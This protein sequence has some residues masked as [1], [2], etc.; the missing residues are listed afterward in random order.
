MAIC[1]RCKQE[2]DGTFGSGRFCSRACANTRNHSEETKEKVSDSLKRKKLS[3]WNKGLTS[4][5]YRIAKGIERRNISFNKKL[6][7]LSFKLWQEL[8]IKQKR[9]IL[10]ES[11]DGK[12]LYCGHYQWL[13]KPL[14]L[15]LHHIDGNNTNQNVNNLEMLCPNCHSLTETFR[16]AN[17]NSNIGLIT[18]EQLIYALKTSKN[19]R[20]ALL[21]VGLAAKGNNYKRAKRLFE[22][23]SLKH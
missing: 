13:N 15:E 16:G 7:C 4:T 10:I 9:W 22:F 6:E 20:Q 2:H 18:D 1:E 12:C 19:I 14:K 21:S 23:L 11:Q 8:S 17:K 3:P 5:D